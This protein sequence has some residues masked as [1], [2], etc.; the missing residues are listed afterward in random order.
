MRMLDGT[1]GAITGVA[2][3]LAVP[4]LVGTSIMI[5]YGRTNKKKPV[6]VIQFPGLLDSY[7]NFD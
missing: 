2:I 4:M 3:V 6:A 1:S 7:D 5:G